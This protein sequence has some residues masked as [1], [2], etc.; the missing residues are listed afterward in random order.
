MP[1]LVCQYKRHLR[2][3]SLSAL[4]S[5]GFILF[6]FLTLLTKHSCEHVDVFSI[7][8]CIFRLHIH[9]NIPSIGKFWSLDWS[10]PWPI[11]RFPL[12]AKRCAGTSLEWGRG[13][14]WM[15]LRG[16]GD[17]LNIQKVPSRRGFSQLYRVKDTHKPPLPCKSLLNGILSAK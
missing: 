12:V 11:L 5:C 15:H 10:A 9:K 8:T 1:F 13:C 6:S 14:T 2:L 17:K 3:I 7:A 4:C 16:W